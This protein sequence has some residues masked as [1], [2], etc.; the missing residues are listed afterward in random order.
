MLGSVLTLYYVVDQYLPF[1]SNSGSSFADQR[2]CGGSTFALS[3][4]KHSDI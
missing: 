4:N 1:D 2:A 3:R